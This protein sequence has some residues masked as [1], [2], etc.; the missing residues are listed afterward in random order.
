MEIKQ[1]ENDDDSY[2]EVIAGGNKKESSF[3]PFAKNFSLLL[4]S[5]FPI[6]LRC[7]M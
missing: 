2:G 7:V 3:P 6:S 4:S 1:Q 5:S